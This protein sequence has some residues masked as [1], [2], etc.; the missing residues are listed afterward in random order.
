MKLTIKI[1]PF[2]NLLI[3]ICLMSGSNDEIEFT[4]VNDELIQSIEENLFE[5]DEKLNM[6]SKQSM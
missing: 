2:Q 5:N 6:S 1:T 3:F 4:F